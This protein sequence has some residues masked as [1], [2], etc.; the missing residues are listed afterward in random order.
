MLFLM[1]NQQCQ[2][3][4]GTASQ[5]K[6]NQVI[7]RMSFPANLLASTEEIKPNTMTKWF[8]LTQKH[9]A[10]ICVSVCTTQHAVLIIFPLK[11]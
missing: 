2:S 4:E 3:T 1:P 5:S 8:K 6:Q 10:H 9:T 11:P 7:L